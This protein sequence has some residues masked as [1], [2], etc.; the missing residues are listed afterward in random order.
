MTYGCLL[1]NIFC[2]FEIKKTSHYVTE[3][4]VERQ[5]ARYEE[6]LLVGITPGGS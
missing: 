1:L 4:E 3:G 5:A 6:S 2:C